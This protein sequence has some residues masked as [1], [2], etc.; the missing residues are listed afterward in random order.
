[1]SSPHPSPT[2]PASRRE[3]L[4]QSS[5]LDSRRWPV[6]LRAGRSSR[7]CDRGSCRRGRSAAC[8]GSAPAIPCRGPRRICRGLPSGEVVGR[9]DV[10]LLEH[11][12]GVVLLSGSSRLIVTSRK[13]R[14]RYIRFIVTNS[15]SSA[16]Q[17]PHQVAQTLTTSNSFVSFRRAWP[18]RTRRS[19]RASP[20]RHPPSP[21]FLASSRLSA[22]FVEQPKTRVFST[23]TGLPASSASTALIVSCDLTVF[24]SA[25]SNRPT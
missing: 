2:V 13:S 9:R 11:L 21:A 18:P 7:P 8:T 4:L 5:D 15:G 23:G 24:T 25:S 19:L 16:T 12:E 1:M 22:H 14:P 17:G 6:A 20:A 3:R 10:P